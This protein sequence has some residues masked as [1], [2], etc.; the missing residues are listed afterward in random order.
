M[1]EVPASKLQLLAKTFIVTVLV[2]EFYHYQL[3]IYLISNDLCALHHC[4]YTTYKI[5][6]TFFGAPCQ[7]GSIFTQN[8]ISNA[9]IPNHRFKKICTS[10]R[11]ITNVLADLTTR[12]GMRKNRLSPRYHWWDGSN[13]WY[14]DKVIVIWW[15]SN[16]VIQWYGDIIWVLL[17]H[18]DSE[19]WK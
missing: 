14:S 8:A 15:Y 3:C 10:T 4:E 6:M 13:K 2:M 16:K 17:K 5:N 9:K 18:C 12:L 19:S 11:N 7:L 1:S